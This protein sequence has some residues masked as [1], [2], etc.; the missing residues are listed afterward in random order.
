MTRSFY[1]FILWMHPPAFRR[2]FRDEML[3]IF[4]EGGARHLKFALLLDGLISFAR[5]WLLRTDSWKILI[6]I[7]GA[8]IQVLP[9]SRGHQ[10]WAKNQQAL[11]P[12]MQEMILLTL[13][14][15]CSLFI[16]IMSLTLWTM[17]FQRRRSDSRGMHLP[18]LAPARHAGRLQARE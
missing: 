1:Q 17:R 15:I 16:M 13:A 4:D 10:D 7:S 9:V 18:G 12:Y 2:R 6:A 3:S 11:T 14:V 8:S 5:Q